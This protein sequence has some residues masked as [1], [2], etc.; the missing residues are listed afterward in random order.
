[1]SEHR[2]AAM[3]AGSGAPLS[4]PPVDHVSGSHPLHDPER[5]WTETNCS[6]DVWVELLHS[7][8]CDPVAGLGF[9][10]SSDFDGS[11]W[12]F[13]KYPLEDV[14]ALY[15][16][17]VVELNIWQPL[18]EHIEEQ[19]AAGRLL[20]VEV[21]SYYLPDTAGVSYQLEHTKTTIVPLQLERSARELTYLHGTGRHELS[22]T[23][24]DS[25]FD[26]VPGA[27]A[28]YVEQLRLDSVDPAAATVEAVFPVV[29]EHLH[30]RPT[31]R[32]AARLVDR[33]TTEL[34]WLAEAGLDGF[35]RWA[36]GTIRQFGA[37]AELAADLVDWLGERGERVPDAAEH[38]RSA[39][40]AARRMQLLTARA[41]AG[42]TVDPTGPG[43]AMVEGWESALKQLAAHFNVP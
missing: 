27:L 11:Q 4:A 39:S 23:D 5:I 32:P 33:I 13:I 7:L 38:L 14:R 8:G 16:I 20:T 22:G 18:V 2:S 21:D 42:R 10:L 19:L 1:M 3:V 31:D 37:T 9:T 17:D 36:F 26:R 41:A 24:F 34:S 12:T 6:V 15:G 43:T 40:A 25:L 29:A 35:H 30:R 28:P